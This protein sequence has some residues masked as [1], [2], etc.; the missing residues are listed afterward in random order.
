MNNIKLYILYGRHLNL[1]E[2]K[3]VLKKKSPPPIKFFIVQSQ[4]CFSQ[5]SF[6]FLE[7]NEILE[8]LM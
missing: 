8:K 6:T 3:F 4:H 5:L 7:N 1:N 2:I